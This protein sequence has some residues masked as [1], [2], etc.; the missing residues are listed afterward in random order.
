MSALSDI[1]VV[2][3]WDGT[4]LNTGEKKINITSKPTFD[5]FVFHIMGQKCKRLKDVKYLLWVDVFL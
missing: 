1:P 5:A 2:E 4:G 3:Y